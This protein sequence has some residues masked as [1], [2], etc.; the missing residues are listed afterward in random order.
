[1]LDDEVEETEVKQS[2]ATSS[3]L[4][5]PVS[6][7]ASVRS[8]ILSIKTKY[9]TGREA[10]ESS[11][12]SPTV[13]TRQET[14]RQASESSDEGLT[15][16]TKTETRQEARQS[17]GDFMSYYVADGD[18]D[19]EAGEAEEAEESA[20]PTLKPNRRL[21]RT[22]P[23]AKEKQPRQPRK[24]QAST[25]L[26]TSVSPVTLH[27]SPAAQVSK[28]TSIRQ[29]PPRQKVRFP[30]A[31]PMGN[32]GL[33]HA[34]PLETVINQRFPP[35]QHAT[36]T[37]NTRHLPSGSKLP[38]GM[39]QS[40]G[41]HGKQPHQAVQPPKPV[42][43]TLMAEVITV[44]YHAPVDVK[45]KKL[46]AL[47]A[48]LT[49]FGPGVP[50][51]RNPPPPAS[52]KMPE[53]SKMSEN[54]EIKQ[55]VKEKAKSGGECQS[56]FLDAPL[57]TF[58][59]DKAV[60]VDNFLAMFDDESD[61]ESENSAKKHAAKKDND[62]G[63]DPKKD[64][65]NGDHPEKKD[66]KNGDEKDSNSKDNDTGDQE[67]QIEV[68]QNR[69]LKHT[70]V[71]DGPLTYGIQFI[72]DAL[73]SW[74]DQRI[75]QQRQQHITMLQARMLPPAVH[76]G[77][78]A[79]PQSL[80][81][82]LNGQ[83]PPKMPD[84]NDTPEGKAIAAFR[85]VV[86]SGCLQVNLILPA[87]LADAVSRLYLQIDHLINQGNRVQPEPPYKPVAYSAQI[88]AHQKRLDRFKDDQAR[89]QQAA[90]QQGLHPMYGMAPPGMPGG[91]PQNAPFQQHMY[92]P[93]AGRRRSTPQVPGQPHVHLS[94]RVSL[95]PGAHGPSQ[96]PSNG[97]FAG[98][99]PAL[100][101]AP[102][103]DGPQGLSD[104]EKMRLMYAP[105]LR[106]PRSGQM[107]NFSFAHAQ[108]PAALQAFGQG[109]FP[110]SK[111]GHG[112]NVPSQP[113]SSPTVV[114]S[115]PGPPSAIQRSVSQPGKYHPKPER[116]SRGASDPDAHA[117]PQPPKPT[118]TPGF[119]A[120]NAP[121]KPVH[122]I[123]GPSSKAKT[124]GHSHSDAVI[125]DDD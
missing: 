45:V 60:P 59:L 95:P 104:E 9:A 70:G 12:E 13:A 39:H 124:P 3:G 63:A 71:P 114:T 92:A 19:E 94:Q 43:Y 65:P 67:P 106:L 120:V 113:L 17:Y 112:P 47:S 38:N 72:M 118:P 76:S 123:R 89:R 119:T 81:S 96:S 78:N 29:Y 51:A 21:V 16:K 99:S 80:A 83:P 4:S 44:K 31:K 79:A 122:D 105:N 15:A 25:P 22:K 90:V 46:Q 101:G 8:G 66:S 115:S 102:R 68:E 5:S 34:P 35:V 74:A 117:H 11:D 50:P 93:P 7:T 33:P 42:P 6:V 110:A 41:M 30:N 1:M 75:R 125:L 62:K 108:N 14:R 121:A 27:P 20:L 86:E 98:N 48:S 111:Q 49:V 10:Q 26:R 82:T 69:Y 85:D 37:A 84:L 100:P 52:G 107:M 77:N 53:S 23:D 40:N 61:D 56:T 91:Y 54:V 2:P 97:T 28:K 32:H 55:D 18:D 116:A 103:P 57:L 87:D 73:H 109:S 64:H 24:K 58:T 88:I 36:H